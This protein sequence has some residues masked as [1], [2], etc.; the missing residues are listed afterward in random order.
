[1]DLEPRKLLTIVTEAALEHEAVRELGRL[2]AAGYTITE[3]R[4]GGHRGVRDGEWQLETN[5]R[6]EVV[7][8]ERRALAIMETF[9]DRF[10]ADFAMIC[11]LSDVRV[12]RAEKFE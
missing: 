9:R 8:S 5:I 4:G 10:F 11:Y 1:M 2:G 3:A 12:L 7:C 6:I